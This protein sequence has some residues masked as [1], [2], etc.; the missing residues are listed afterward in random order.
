MSNEHRKTD[1]GFTVTSEG[2]I[3]HLVV[4]VGGLRILAPVKLSMEERS[5]KNYPAPC[6]DGEGHLIFVLPGGVEVSSTIEPRKRFGRQ[7]VQRCR[8]MAA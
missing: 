8:S 6:R 4:L 1:I 3:D 5:P 7:R 2:M